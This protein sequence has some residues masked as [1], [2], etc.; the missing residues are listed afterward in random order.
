[1]FPLTR[2]PFWYRFFEPRPFVCACCQ[3]WAGR[4]MP[5]ARLACEEK[6]KEIFCR[7]QCF[8]DMEEY[9]AKVL[10]RQPIRMEIGAV[11]SHA[12]SK[13]NVVSKDGQIKWGWVKI[14]P[15]GDCRF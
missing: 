6:G 2:V 7:Y 14:K 4:V 13:H 15:P 11:F 1:M 12:P 3:S 8:K 5:A 9:R 10:D